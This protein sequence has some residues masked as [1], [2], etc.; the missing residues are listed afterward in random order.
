[1]VQVIPERNGTSRREWHRVDPGLRDGLAAKPVRRAGTR[2]QWGVRSR[3]AA[4]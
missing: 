1:M 2:P 3:C 4:V